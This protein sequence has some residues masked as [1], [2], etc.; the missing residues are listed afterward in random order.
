LHTYAASTALGVRT[1]RS[2]GARAIFET[3]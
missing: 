3:P 2:D 1:R